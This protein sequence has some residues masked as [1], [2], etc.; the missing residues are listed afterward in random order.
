MRKYGRLIDGPIPS[1]SAVGTPSSLPPIA[2]APKASPRLTNTGARHFVTY[3]LLLLT[4]TAVLPIIML[5]S[6]CGGQ[7]CPSAAALA[8]LLLLPSVKRMYHQ[9]APSN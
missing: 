3:C 8:L 9:L 2:G 6:G 4:A 1:R 7:L 5:H